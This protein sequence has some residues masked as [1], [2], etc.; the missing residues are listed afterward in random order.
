MK[1]ILK[2]DVMLNTNQPEEPNF[3]TEV[4]RVLARMSE[5][6]AESLQYNQ[7]AKNLKELMEAKGLKSKATISPEA[8]LA[9]ATN[10]A[11]ILLILNFEKL[12]IVTTKAIG[13]ISKGR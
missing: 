13:F 4:K 1:P 3:E 2:G 12:D 10:I 8:I 7:A 9:A 5:L 6:D 11:G